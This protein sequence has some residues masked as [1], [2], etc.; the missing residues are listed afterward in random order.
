MAFGSA[1]VKNRLIILSALIAN[2]TL[3][4]AA[5]IDGP[6]LLIQ[7]RLA[8]FGEFIDISSGEASINAKIDSYFK[9][10]RASH[11]GI[12]VAYSNTLVEIEEAAKKNACIFTYDQKVTS[13]YTTK[14]DCKVY[15]L[16]KLLIPG[17]GGSQCGNDGDL[18]AR[19]KMVVANK[20]CCS[21]FTEA[22]LVFANL[23]GV[24]AREVHDGSHTT[25]EYYDPNDNKWKWVDPQYKLQMA[26]GNTIL[27]FYEISDSEIGDNLL[28]L[29]ALNAKYR[30]PFLNVW[31]KNL[32]GYTL[33]SNV[34]E[35]EEFEERIRLIPLLKPVYQLASHLAGV[36]PGYLWVRT[37][38]DAAIHG[39]FK[40]IAMAYALLVILANL[41]VVLHCFKCPLVGKVM[42][43]KPNIDSAH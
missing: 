8:I 36:R 42:G 3:L 16:M 38:S 14:T 31:N 1:F 9:A 29:D 26:K 21:D 33:G 22:F 15:G 28:A 32:I 5:L 40:Y 27:S 12:R 10:G 18:E 37:R 17:K 43:K 23:L 30:S 19:V 2:T 20:G 25:V 13:V 11:S 4:L 39:L 24:R 35:V 7:S 6:G 41:A 34:V